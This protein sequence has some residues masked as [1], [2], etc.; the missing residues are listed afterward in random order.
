MSME[1][2]LL[3]NS[4]RRLDR[5]SDVAHIA[6]LVRLGVRVQDIDDLVEVWESLR[7]PRLVSTSETINL[8]FPQLKIELVVALYKRFGRETQ[9]LDDFADYVLSN[10]SDLV[11]ELD[12]KKE[13]FNWK[14]LFELA[15]SKQP[16]KWQS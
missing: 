2:Q 8:G 13:K 1:K 12:H 5:G 16:D 7:Q 11:E 9:V 15:L 10:F 3:I 4:I 14:S 6:D